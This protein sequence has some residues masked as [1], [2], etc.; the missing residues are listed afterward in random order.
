MPQPGILAL[1]GIVLNT[2]IIF[3]EFAVI[4]IMDNVQ[5]SNNDSSGPIVG[6]TR[7]EFHDCLIRAGQPRMPSLPSWS[8]HFEFNP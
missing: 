5:Q 4:L 1:F 2:A 8:K 3:V 7:R 6:L